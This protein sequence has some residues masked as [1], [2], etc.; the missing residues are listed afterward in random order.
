MHKKHNFLMSQFHSLSQ[1]TG[2][3]KNA[4]FWKLLGVRSSNFQ[5]CL[6]FMIPKTGESLMKI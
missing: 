5:D 6:V 1:H 4:I 2:N 3:L